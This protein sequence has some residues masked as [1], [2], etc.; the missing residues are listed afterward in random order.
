MQLITP[1]TTMK[2]HSKRNKKLI[3][4]T[5]SDDDLKMVYTARLA[6]AADRESGTRARENWLHAAVAAG[7]ELVARGYSHTSVFMAAFFPKRR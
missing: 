5:L 2:I 3:L 7:D 1:T 4:H 6:I